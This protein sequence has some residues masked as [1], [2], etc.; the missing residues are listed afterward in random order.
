MKEEVGKEMLGE[1][2]ETAFEGEVRK[3][4]RRE[5]MKMMKLMMEGNKVKSEEEVDRQK[6]KKIIAKYKQFKKENVKHFRFHSKA[7][8]TTFGMSCLIK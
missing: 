4:V 6:F 7:T 8:T 3:E 1:E 2:V 5:V